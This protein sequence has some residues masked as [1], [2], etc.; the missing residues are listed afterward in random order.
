MPEAI[1]FRFDGRNPDAVRMTDAYL[2]NYTWRVSRETRDA[3]EA[4]VRRSIDEGIE[5]LKAARMIEDVV[6]LT[7][8]QA[9]AVL[10]YRAGLESQGVL[11]ASRIEKLV[12]K[13]ADRKLRERGETIARTEIVG[14]LVAGELAAARQARDRGFLRGEVMKRWRVTEL[15]EWPCD[16]CDPLDGATVPLDDLFEGGVDGPPLHPRCRCT[17]TAVVPLP[18]EGEEAVPAE[19][20][21]EGEEAEVPAEGEEAEVA[22]E[23]EEDAE[24]AEGVAAIVGLLGL[25]GE[26]SDDEVVDGFLE[27]E[28]LTDS[29]TD[30]VL[31]ATDEERADLVSDAA[32]EKVADVAEREGADPDAA[33]AALA[34]ARDA[35]PEGFDLAAEALVFDA[36]AD[37]ETLG[38]I[39]DYLRGRGVDV[40]ELDDLVKR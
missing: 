27:V 38:G 29:T 39:A 28:D 11:D 5:P 14:S 19:A 4:I 34:R 18:E 2:R 17:V 36:D 7:E 6:G 35:N 12:A 26:W 30:D 31:D 22:A 25:S 9:A 32:E 10:N 33:R 3:I 13:Y 15:G 24:A 1:A 8:R 40:P 21:A 37:D 16:R 23:G 20:E